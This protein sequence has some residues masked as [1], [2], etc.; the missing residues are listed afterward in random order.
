MMCVYDA[1]DWPISVRWL[2][3]TRRFSSST[4]TG[5]LRM[6]VAVGTVSDDSMFATIFEAAPRRG[7]AL[8]VV[9]GGAGTGVGRGAG[10]GA[11]AGA[12]AGRATGAGAAAAAEATAA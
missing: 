10:A 1:F 11:A 4:L 9:G 6:E 7:T 5:M 12:A 3:I 8:P 2:L